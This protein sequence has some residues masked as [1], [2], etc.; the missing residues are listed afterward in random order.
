MRRYFQENDIKG[1]VLIAFS[2]NCDGQNKNWNVEA[3]WLYLIACGYFKKKE[4]HFPLL[5]HSTMASE[6]DFS[7]VAVYQTKYLH[8]VFTP[9][10]WCDIVSK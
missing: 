1:E 8:N 9:D 3:F 6:R 4:H 7:R 5:R 2:D 10:H